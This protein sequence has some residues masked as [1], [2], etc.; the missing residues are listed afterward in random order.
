MLIPIVALSPIEEILSVEP[1]ML[2][3]SK[4]HDFHHEISF[5][6]ILKICLGMHLRKG[7]HH[8]NVLH[9]ITFS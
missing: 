4:E 5:N 6:K 1:T 8:V 9:I 3:N 2:E 7:M